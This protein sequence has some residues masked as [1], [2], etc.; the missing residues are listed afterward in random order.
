[1]DS[2][3]L[4]LGDPLPRPQIERLELDAETHTQFWYLCLREFDWY[5]SRVQSRLLYHNKSSASREGTQ[6]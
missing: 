5:G 1:M 2:K 6:T 3:S 4:R